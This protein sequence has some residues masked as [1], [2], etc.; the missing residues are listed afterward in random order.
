MLRTIT[1]T[2]DLGRNVEITVTIDGP[3][4][5]LPSTQML[6]GVTVDPDDLPRMARF[7]QARHTRVFWPPKAGLPTWADRRLQWLKTNAPLV[8]PHVSFKD[9]PSDA[10][11]TKGVTAFLDGMT[12]PT[13]TGTADPLVMLTWMHEGDAKGVDSGDYRRR[14][15]TLQ[16]IVGDHPNGPLVGTAPIQT[17]QWTQGVAKG[18]GNGDLSRYYAGV[19]CAGIDCYAN[20]WDPAYPDPAKFLHLALQLA[21]RSGGPPCLPELGAVRLASDPS[22]R[23]RADWIRAVATILKSEGCRVVSWWDAIGTGGT[24]FRLDD[25]PS[26]TA[27]QDVCAGRI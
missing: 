22:G 4:P 6:A 1:G 15:W 21:A 12:A 11:V 25:E 3:D 14:W 9:W 13:V 23:G 5:A 24:D 17:L 27:W 7:P 18:K 10:A 2:D 20:S 19:G 8:V 16:G 26:R